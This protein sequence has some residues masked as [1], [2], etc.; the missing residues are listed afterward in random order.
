MHV[1]ERTGEPSQ[2]EQGCKSSLTNELRA[3]VISCRII[4]SE[5]WETAR[6][7][8]FFSCEKLPVQLLDLRIL[9]ATGERVWSVEQEAIID[10]ANFSK[11]DLWDKGGAV[12]FFPWIA[13]SNLDENL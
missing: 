11:S 9:K 10:I 7:I 4:L 3:S 12:S 2:F 8:T 6:R 1:S 5:D 13:L